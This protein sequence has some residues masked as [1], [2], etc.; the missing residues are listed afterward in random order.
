MKT[1][2]YGDAEGTPPSGAE[3]PEPPDNDPAN[4]DYC[5][6]CFGISQSVTGDGAM[7]QFLKGVPGGSHVAGGHRCPVCVRRTDGA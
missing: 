7:H 5:S 1:I 3:H 4:K 6:N 2:A